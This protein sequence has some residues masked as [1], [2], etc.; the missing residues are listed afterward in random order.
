MKSG[1]GHAARFQQVFVRRVSVQ[2]PRPAVG[3]EDHAVIERRG[4]KSGHTGDEALSTARVSGDQ[5]VND[6]ARE[7]DPVRLP[8]LAVDLDAIPVARRAD[9]HQA[10]VVGRDVV[11]RANA[12]VDLL[13]E[14]QL[15]LIVRLRPV[16]AQREHDEDIAIG[17]ARGVQSGDEGRQDQIGAGKTCDVVYH[18]R[19][20]LAPVHDVAKRS[21]SDGVIDRMADR[22]PLII[23]RIHLT[24]NQPVARNARGEVSLAVGQVIRYG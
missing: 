18:D 16:N 19:D 3:V 11:E 8:H 15:A 9:L 23:G 17:N 7:D 13:A 20:A 4:S 22:Q 21:G 6:L 14:Y 24:R 5:V 1:S 10:V 2:L 12:G